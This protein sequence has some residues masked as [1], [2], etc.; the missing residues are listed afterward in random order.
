MWKHMQLMK[1]LILFHMFLCLLPLQICVQ[2]VQSSY[3]N[4]FMQL[5]IRLSGIEGPLY[6]FRCPSQF[7]L[8]LQRWACDICDVFYTNWMQVRCALLLFNCSYLFRCPSQFTVILQRCACDI[9]FVF[10]TYWMQVRCV[11]LLIEQMKFTLGW[12]DLWCA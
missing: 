4:L 3:T 2:F 5:T 11:L 9:C 1:R 12:K 6:I 10:Y 8:A 7:I